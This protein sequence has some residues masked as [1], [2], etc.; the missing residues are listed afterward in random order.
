MKKWQLIAVAVFMAV[1]I[2]APAMAFETVFKG[3]YEVWGV[4]HDKQTLS[5]NTSVAN[6]SPPLPPGSTTKPVGTNSYF[7][8][9]L[10]TNV[11]FKITDNTTLVT[12]FKALQEKWGTSEYDNFGA[13]DDVDGSNFAWYEAFMVIKTKIGGFVIGRMP[14]GPWGTDFHDTTDPADRFNWVIPVDNWKFAFTY[15]KWNEYDSQGSPFDTP[16]S[17]Y[18]QSDTD[19]DKYY[20]S[21]QYKDDQQKF[22]LLGSFYRVQTL[23]DLG[24][25]DTKAVYDLALGPAGVSPV[26]QRPIEADVYVLTPY[27]VGSFGNFDLT[28]EGLYAWGKGEYT[29]KDGHPLFGDYWSEKDRDL[30]VFSYWA[31]V[32]YNMGP[33]AVSGGWAHRS[34][35]VIG[36]DDDDEFTSGGYI[37]SGG[38]WEK[39]FI[40]TNYWHAGLYNTL[41]GP[42]L[43][44]NGNG[45]YTMGNLAGQGAGASA[46]LS[47]T[48]VNGFQMLYLSLEYAPREDMT[49]EFLWATSKADKVLDQ[50][51]G[52]TPVYNIPL[53][54]GAVQVPKAAEKWDDDHGMEYDLNCTWKIYDNVTWRTTFAYLDAGD[55]WKQGQAN[56]KVEDLFSAFTMV[57]LSF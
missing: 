38:D 10:D 24:T 40:L 5:E 11:I 29:F 54:G 21:A 42:A 37:E 19:N 23:V 16:S 20:L 49:I 18:W 47:Q 14:D 2:A 56:A 39:M 4:S 27:Y 17:E 44:D 6:P 22:G 1:L 12:R 53:A 46:N 31:D 7:E 26:Y 45:N 30:K 57:T 9:K 33:V 43:G 52:L 28:F 34:G 35:D 51:A 48:A 15:E 13:N 3:F 25:S 8:M 36:Q 50:K 55:Y 41:G 32:K